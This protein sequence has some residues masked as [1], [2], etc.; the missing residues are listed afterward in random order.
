MSGGIENKVVV[1]TGASSGL[2]EATARHLA[3]QGATI[4]LG[5]RRADRIEALAQELTAAGHR[6]KAVPTDVTDRDQVKHLVDTVVEEFGRVDVMLNNAGL[7]PLAP[8]ER[9]KVDEWDRMIDVNIKGVLYGVA[10]ALPHMKGQRS[11]H[12]INVSSVYGHVVDPGATVYCAT[13]FAVRAL[14]EGLRREVKP[15]NIRT[16]VV[17]PGAVSTE[18]LEHI[19]EKDIQAETKEFVSK[20]AVGAD[21]FARMVAFAVNEPDEVDVNEILF[22]PTAQ[23]V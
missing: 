5:A 13:K 16:T 22:R 10:A 14:S 9:L 7:M 1:I 18:L 11:G 6:A 20:I 3:A 21:T 4:V 2:G 15:Y 19:G 17:S 23:P 8:L 12:I